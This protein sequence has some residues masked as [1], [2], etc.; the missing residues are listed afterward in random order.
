[1][2]HMYHKSLLVANKTCNL[3]I[4]KCKLK[5]IGGE[6]MFSEK[7]YSNYILSKNLYNYCIESATKEELQFLLNELLDV[8]RDTRIKINAYKKLI[9]V[10]ET[11]LTTLEEIINECQNSSKL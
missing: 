4:N 11:R 8:R 2:K 6:I 7:F 3:Y 9:P 1:M 10:L 5:N